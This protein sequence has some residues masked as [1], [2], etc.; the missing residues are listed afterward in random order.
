MYAPAY[1]FGAAILGDALTPIQEVTVTTLSQNVAA[2][3]LGCLVFGIV[4]AV[5]GYVI[6][7]TLWRRQIVRQWRI[8]QEKR[9]SSSNNSGG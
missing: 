2:L 1:L 7:N 9:R 6:V 4:F 8:R 5:L 3:L